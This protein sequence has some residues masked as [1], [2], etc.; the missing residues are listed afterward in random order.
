MFVTPNMG[1]TAWDQPDD[2]YDHTQLATNFSDIDDH[3]H[4]LGKGKQIPSGGLA[5]DAVTGD[6]LADNAVN[7]VVHI[8]ASSIPQ[9][10]LGIDSVGNPQLQD[11][12]VGPNELQDGAVTADKLDPSIQPIGQ[13]MLWYR[14][15]SAVLPPNGWEVM[16]GRAWSTIPNSLGAGGTQWN[17][18]NIPNMINK[19]P[20]GAAL[21]GTGITPDLPPDIGA[22]GGSQTRDLSHTHTTNAHSH[23]VD[24]HAHGISADGGHAHRFTGLGPGGPILADLFS[25][26]VG[27][28]KAD[29]TRQALYLQGHNQ[30]SF[31]GSDVALP[32]EVVNNHTHTGSTGSSSAGTNAA[33]VSVNN[34]LTGSTD[35]RPA[36][37]G[38]LFLMKVN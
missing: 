24:A 38:L 16:D 15:D 30:N 3:D 6:K 18:G 37:V 23:T 29:G 14:A 27:V 11:D 33:T 4:S 9:S 12:S 22:A 20:L 13:V 28:P 32:M 7:P 35:L 2:N 1:L 19:F 34:G 26:D 5:N 10:R 17:T 36:Y 25:R 31:V 21:A 8:P